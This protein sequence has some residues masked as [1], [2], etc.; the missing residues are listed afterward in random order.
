MHV[1]CGFHLHLSLCDKHSYYA[2]WMVILLVSLI[3]NSYS[4]V[5]I[6][7]SLSEIVNNETGLK[8]IGLNNKMITNA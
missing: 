8:V 5:L 6:Y 1:W 4:R 2:A 3:C 7:H